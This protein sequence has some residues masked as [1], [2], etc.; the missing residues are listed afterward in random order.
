MLTLCCTL[1]LSSPA[2]HSASLGLSLEPPAAPF[3]LRLQSPVEPGPGGEAKAPLT[4]PCFRMALVIAAIIL[5]VCV[6]EV[7]VLVALFPV[8]GPH[9][10]WTDVPAQLPLALI[11]RDWGA[12]VLIGRIPAG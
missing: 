3:T 4:P 11:P 8:G 6:I 5:L 7:T 1:I 10:R 9:E 12:E 2:T